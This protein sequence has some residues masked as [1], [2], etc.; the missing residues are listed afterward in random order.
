MKS[1]FSEAHA[2]AIFLAMRRTNFSDSMTHGPRMKTGRLPPIDTFPDAQWFCFGHEC[3]RK[4]GAQEIKESLPAFLLSGLIL[5]RY[6]KNGE[7]RV[8]HEKK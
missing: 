1:T 8:E 2:S 6:I 3:L 7:R 5:F 4:A